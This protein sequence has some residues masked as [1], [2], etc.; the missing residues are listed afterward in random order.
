MM[1]NFKNY[2]ETE[3][4]RSLRTVTTYADDVKKFK[5]YVKKDLLLV[6][7]GDVRKF[8]RYLVKKELKPATINL[9][10]A[11]IKAF[12]DWLLIEK[13][14]VTSP[15][16]DGLCFRV[17]ETIIDVP[18]GE[19]IDKMINSAEK[20]RD[21]FMISALASS[22]L[23]ISE[24]LKL[25][26]DDIGEDGSIKVRQGKGGKDRYTFMDKRS[27][28]IYKEYVSMLKNRG[29][30][31]LFRFA[32]RQAWNII[33]SYAKKAGIKKNVKPHSFRHYFITQMGRRGMSDSDLSKFSGHKNVNT[34]ARYKNYSIEVQREVYK[35]YNS[36]KL[37]VLAV[38]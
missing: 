7:E 29:I 17:P 2:L 38:V 24:L 6:Q 34:L 35:K 14:V 36:K 21:K 20:L 28:K 5:N 19:E 27:Q 26:T 22:G 13:R 31:K 15:V 25:T 10:L 12:Y 16:P 30:K 32:Y 9:S 33:K 8:K 37:E 18:L 11:A 3:K 1:D 23:R 4:R